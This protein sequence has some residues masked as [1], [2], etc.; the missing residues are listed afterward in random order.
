MSLVVLL[1]FGIIGL[2]LLAQDDRRR[3]ERQLRQCKF[4]CHPLFFFFFLS[5]ELRLRVCIYPYPYGYHASG[6]LLDVEY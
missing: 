5:C 2:Y 1:S 3:L 6:L 4:L